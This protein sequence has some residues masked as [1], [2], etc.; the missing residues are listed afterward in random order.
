M[1]LYLMIFGCMITTAAAISLLLLYLGEIRRNRLLNAKLE[2]IR[3]ADYS[4]LSFIS[5]I[6]DAPERLTDDRLIM[7]LISQM[8]KK[9]VTSLN[10]MLRAYERITKM[11]GGTARRDTKLAFIIACSQK[12][13]KSLADL[14]CSAAIAN[15]KQGIEGL[16]SIIKEFDPKQAE[17]IFLLAEQ[18]IAEYIEQNVD[19]VLDKRPDLRLTLLHLKE[20]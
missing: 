6:E 10:S 15:D 2:A 3:M 8:V 4:F 12:T 16:I 1:M 9:E 18:M 17:A 11:P 13:D 14:Y 19:D 20:I 7:N 5:S